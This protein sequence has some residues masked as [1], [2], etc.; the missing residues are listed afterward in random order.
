[1][2][3]W[4]QIESGDVIN[5]LASGRRIRGVVINDCSAS[6]TGV[7]ELNDKSVGDILEMIQ[8][9]CNLFFEKVKEEEK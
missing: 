6:Y 4:K 9:G 5:H 1:M 7:Y 8:E 2:S 3:K